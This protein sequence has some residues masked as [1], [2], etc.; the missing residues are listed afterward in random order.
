M[1]RMLTPLVFMVVAPLS[2][3]TIS[4]PG[5]LICGAP[6][7]F[8]TSAANRDLLVRARAVSVTDRVV[9]LGLPGAGVRF[10]PGC[11]VFAARIEGS[12]VVGRIESMDGDES[13]PLERIRARYRT[14]EKPL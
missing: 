14:P 10:V 2:A 7:P 8:T 6:A 3:Q 12:N 9:S 1:K 4:T 5:A 11:G 13:V